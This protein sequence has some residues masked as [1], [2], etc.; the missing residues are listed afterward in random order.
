MILSSENSILV[1]HA[2]GRSAPFDPYAL[3][4]EI[5]AVCRDSGVERDIALAV[6]YA[7]RKQCRETGEQC[8]KR[9]EIDSMIV[10][11]F[12]GVG[13][14]QAAELFRR[15]STLRGDIYRIP[16]TRMEFFLS[17]KFALSGDT[18]KRIAAK[19]VNTLKRKRRRCRTG[20]GR[21]LPSISS[22]LN[23]KD[24][25]PYTVVRPNFRDAAK[26]TVTSAEIESLFP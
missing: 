16:V 5:A 6:E 10:A 18:L 21:S 8:F 15:N 13:M 22:D 12:E 7:L 11:I 1:I 25:L 9:S 26:Y 14:S 4:K 2:D 24:V 20:L 19:I 17:E 3:E 23:G